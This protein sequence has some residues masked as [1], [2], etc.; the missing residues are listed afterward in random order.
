MLVSFD[1]V[2]MFPSTDNESGL[3]AEKNALE[4]REEQFPTT[5]C[6]TEALEL[7]LKCYSS[8]FNKKH[9]FQTDGTAAGPHIPCSYSDIAIEKFDKK[10]LEY[11]PPV[12]GWKRYQDV[13]SMASLCRRS[14]RTIVS[15]RTKKI[16][17]T[18]EVAEDVLEFLD[19][20]RT[21]KKEYKR[22]TLL[23]KLLIVLQTYFPTPVFLRTALKTFLKVLHFD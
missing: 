22:N 8:I 2:N 12:I 4:A 23:P 19:L 17:F 3:Q 16:R 6:I 15:D 14:N 13:F 7:C 11:N 21:F 18:M 1:I 10:S 20:K 9:Y 5:L